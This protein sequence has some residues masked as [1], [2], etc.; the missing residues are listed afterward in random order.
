MTTHTRTTRTTAPR[1]T[2]VPKKNTSVRKTVAPGKTVTLRKTPAQSKPVAHPKPVAS[3]RP[4]APEK[5]MASPKPPASE[6]LATPGGKKIGKKQS[7]QSLKK[8]LSR[9]SDSPKSKIL[10]TFL[11]FPKDIQ[12]DGQDRG[13]QVVLVIRQHPVYFISHA[14]KA[15]GVAITIVALA[16]LMR[17]PGMDIS[18]SLSL[19]ISILGIMIGVSVLVTAFLKWYFSVNIVTDE[20]IL[21]VDFTRVFAHRVSECQLENIEDVSHSSIGLWSTIFDFGSVFIQTAAE[22]R[23]FDF[24]KV[25]RPRDIQDTILDLSELVQNGGV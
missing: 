4:M 18:V 21:D 19:A 10:P 5:P 11:P 25:P 1:S 20:R 23:E 22:Q 2:S 16:M 24:L 15:I 7:I 3:K 6:K 9:I 14:A 8:H 12:F 17:T 13:E